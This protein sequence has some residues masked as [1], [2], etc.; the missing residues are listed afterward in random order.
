[1]T[2]KKHRNLGPGPSTKKLR[3][4]MK[5]MTEFGVTRY[6][7]SEVE[8]EMP[9]NYEQGATTSSFDFGSYDSSEEKEKPELEPRDDLGYTEEDYL[10]RSAEA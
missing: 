5:L 1:M 2:E 10:W 6:R 4:M 3:A 8:I 7:D 9:L